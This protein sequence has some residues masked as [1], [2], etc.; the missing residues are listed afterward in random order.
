MMSELGRKQKADTSAKAR[1]ASRERVVVDDKMDREGI[2][3][4]K[5]A[6]ED[7]AEG[8]IGDELDPTDSA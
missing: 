8:G 2:R 7:D 1:A 3:G 5:V 4:F 6:G